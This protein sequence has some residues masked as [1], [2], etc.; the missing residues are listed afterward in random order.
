MKVRV[1]AIGTIFFFKVKTIN[2]SFFMLA[3]AKDHLTPKI[4]HKTILR[5]QDI[6]NAS[7]AVQEN[8]EPGW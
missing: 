1:T 2:V 6:R 7:Q 3:L 4:F 8:V 5:L